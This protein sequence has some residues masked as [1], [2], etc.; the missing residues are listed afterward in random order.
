MVAQKQ[1][2]ILQLAGMDNP[3]VTPINLYNTYGKILELQGYKDVQTFFSDPMQWE[4][5]PEKPDPALMLAQLQMEQIRAD[6]ATKTEDLRIK[7]E[8][9]MLEQDFKRDE[10]DAEIILKSKELEA[11][12]KESIDLATIKAEIEKAKAE[13]KKNIVINLPSERKRKEVVRDGNGNIIAVEETP[14]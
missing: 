11:R 3:L 12:Y 10:L 8:T 14:V 9:M 6:M 2:A 5:P 4:P 1:E 13:E 7:R